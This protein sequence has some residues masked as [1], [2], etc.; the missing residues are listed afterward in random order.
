[1]HT[2]DINTYRGRL[3]G[4]LQAYEH[5]ALSR[6]GLHPQRVQ[7]LRVLRDCIHSMYDPALLESEL[8]TYLGK[9]FIRRSW[10]AYFWGQP[11]HSELKRML[12]VIMADEQAKTWQLEQMA[13]DY[14]LY[15]QVLVE[16]RMGGGQG[17]DGKCLPPQQL[18]SGYGGVN[19]KKV[20]GAI[21]WHADV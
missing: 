15:Q 18:H 19:E 7:D 8:Q 4:A 20:V 5:K 2:W 21:G 14:H 13:N 3:L 17:A 16:G 10:S 6:G 11:L 9:M 1:M 12:E